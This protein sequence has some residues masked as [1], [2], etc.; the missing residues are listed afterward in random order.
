[1]EHDAATVSRHHLRRSGD[2]ESNQ[3][4]P[5]RRARFHDPYLEHPREE[6][7]ITFSKEAL[8]QSQRSH[9]SPDCT[10]PHNQ[11]AAKNELPHGRDG[12][13]VAAVT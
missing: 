1:V 2:G 9:E 11:R 12:N 10:I 8:V 7:D 5:R 4:H 13:L 3:G 6:N